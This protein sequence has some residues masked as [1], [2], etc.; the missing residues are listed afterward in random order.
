MTGQTYYYAKLLIAG[1][2]ISTLLSID[3][4]AQNPIAPNQSHELPGKKAILLGNTRYNLPIEKYRIW[5][6]PHDKTS[7]HAAFGFDAILPDVAPAT[8]DLTEAKTWGTGTG[9]HR[10][11][12]VLVEYGRNFISQKQQFENAIQQSQTMKELQ[13]TEISKGQS[14][15]RFK[16]IYKDNYAKLDNG[17]KKYEGYSIGGNVMQLCE[18]NGDL[19]VIQCHA[20]TE[21]N[22]YKLSPYCTVMITIDETT[23]LTYSYSYSYFDLAPDIHHRLVDLITS[24]RVE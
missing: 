12:H 8:S 16:Y 6:Q 2:V 5:I 1:I 13:D 18:K 23:Q 24:F 7:D 4:N 20:E 10:D 19:L 11:V 21:I 3:S 9:W 22:N 14:V 17:C 15:A